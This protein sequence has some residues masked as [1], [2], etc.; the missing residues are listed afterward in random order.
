MIWLLAA[1][2]T[3][4]PLISLTGSSFEKRLKTKQF[5]V[6]SFEIGRVTHQPSINFGYPVLSE[7]REVKAVIFAALDVSWL[8]AHEQTSNVTS[9]ARFDLRQDGFEMG[10]SSHINQTQVKGSEK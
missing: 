2:P 6:G 5:S 7:S 8:S 10:L 9:R 1:F 4:R 3:R